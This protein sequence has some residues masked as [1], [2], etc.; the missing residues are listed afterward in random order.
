MRKPGGI[1][2]AALLVLALLTSCSRKPSATPQTPADVRTVGVLSGSYHAEL[3]QARFPDVKPLYFPDLVSMALAL[4]KGQ[5]DAFACIKQGSAHL[6][7]RYPGFS[8]LEGAAMPDS[9]SLAFRPEE[10]ALAGRFNAFLAQIRSDGTYAAMQRNWFGPDAP[11]KPYP[12]AHG[13]GDPIVAGIE[14][15]QTFMTF[16]A[17]EGEAGFEPELILRFGEY[18]GRPV[19]FRELTGSGMVPALLSG[20]VD[21]LCCGITPTAPRREKLLF[22]QAYSNH[23][24]GFVVR[25]AHPEH[26][27]QPGFKERFRETLVVDKRYKMI[28][29]GLWMTLLIS[30]SSMLLG[31]L[32][33]ILLC[34]CRYSR[35]RFLQEFSEGYCTLIEGIPIL[36]ILLVMF[37]VVFAASHLTA[38]TVAIITYSLFFAAGACECFHTGIASVDPLQREAALSLGF[39]PLQA[40]RYV[41]VPQSMK[42]I[43]PLFKGRAIGL[44]E[45]TSIVGFIAIKDLTKVIDV[46]RNQT[47]ESVISLGILAL[48]Y[49]LLTRLIGFCLDW[50]GNKILSRHA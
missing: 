42:T 20:R 21:I 4:E 5:I 18:L 41:V 9:S 48:I 32:L 3:V 17:E 1:H 6:L 7:D 36:V 15:G 2:L 27:S 44:I 39:T 49:F 8:F 19:V 22:S 25:S 43:I 31:G 33:G 10:T 11:R 26:V 12:H 30:F 45:N 24:V 14:V 28:L 37:Y 34:V 40:Y 50:I 35:R 23:D 29:Q 16:A 46:L 38:V 47:Y 13:S